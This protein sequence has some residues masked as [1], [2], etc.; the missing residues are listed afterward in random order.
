MLRS[1]IVFAFETKRLIKTN[2]RAVHRSVIKERAKLINLGTFTPAIFAILIIASNTPV[3][4]A[5][6]IRI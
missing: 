5:I 6:V 2:V 4:T 3:A 1:L